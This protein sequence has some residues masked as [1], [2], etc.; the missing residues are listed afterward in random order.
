[1]SEK[2]QRRFLFIRS[3]SDIWYFAYIS[4]VRQSSVTW[5]RLN[6]GRCS[7]YLGNYFPEKKKTAYFRK[8]TPITGESKMTLCS[9][10]AI[11][12]HICLLYWFEKPWREKIRAS[13]LHILLCS[14]IVSWEESY[15]HF[16]WDNLV[17]GLFLTLQY[18]HVPDLCPLM[19]EQ[20]QTP[21][22]LKMPYISKCPPQGWYCYWWKPQI[23][24][25]G[26]G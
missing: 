19:P 25:Q 9:G 13:N 21:W 3:T 5:S 20:S 6:T 14:I 10:F 4:L 26:T 8:G 22:Q 23:E 24:F 11:L 18:I 12:Y 17:D 2:F 7:Y 16:E 1:M 15:W